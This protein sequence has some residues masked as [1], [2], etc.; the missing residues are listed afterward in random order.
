MLKEDPSTQIARFFVVVMVEFN[1]TVS[2][3]GVNSDERTIH[4]QKFSENGQSESNLD[5]SNE[6][7]ALIYRTGTLKICFKKPQ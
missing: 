1:E 5:V 6:I 3:L 2:G 7:T 4:F